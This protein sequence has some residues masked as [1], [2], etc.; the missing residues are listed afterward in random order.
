[1]TIQNPTPWKWDGIAISDANGEIVI[2]NH[3]SSEVLAANARLIV[4]AVNAYIAAE[5]QLTILDGELGDRWRSQAFDRNQCAS[6]D[7]ERL[8]ISRWLNRIG[9]MEVQI[10]K[11]A[12]CYVVFAKRTR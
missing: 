5:Q 8:T 11:G 7:G 3:R 9:A 10:V 6:I 4:A 2:S 12:D 1:M